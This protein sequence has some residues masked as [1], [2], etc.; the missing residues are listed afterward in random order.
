MA[1]HGNELSLSQVS[2][3]VC[4][5]GRRRRDVARAAGARGARARRGT[6]LGLSERVRSTS[7]GPR[8]DAFIPAL[9]R[10]DKLRLPA[11]LY[12]HV[13]ML[14]SVAMALLGVLMVFAVMMGAAIYLVAG[15]PSA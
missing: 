13:R 12:A 15:A 11:D 9:A 6:V 3:S 10:V 14:S 7:D 2:Q 1:V 5:R 8:T 4:L